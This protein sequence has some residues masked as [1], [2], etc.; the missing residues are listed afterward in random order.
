M[1]HVTVVCY[2]C[3]VMS[4]KQLAWETTHEKTQSCFLYA[5]EAA[6]KC[7]VLSCE[8]ISVRRVRK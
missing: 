6:I 8:V 4:G 3:A 5:G 7:H 1:R 2:L